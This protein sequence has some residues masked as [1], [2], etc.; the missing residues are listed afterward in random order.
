MKILHFYK[1]YFPY[2]MGGIEQVINQVAIGVKKLGIETEVL[3]LT[4]KKPNHT[5]M[6]DGHKVH[7]CHSNFSF[8]STPF[9]LEAFSEFSTLVKEAD[10]IH[11]HFPYPFTDILHFC[12]RVKK[13]TIV[14]YHL[15]IVKQKHLL[16]L[17]R[18]LMNHFLKNVGHIVAT[19]PNYIRTSKIL[20]KFSAKTTVIPIGL[21]KNTYPQLSQEKLAYWSKK[22]PKRFFLF[23]GVFRYYKGLHILLEAAKYNDYPIVIIGSGPMEKQLKEQAQNLDLNNIY[24]LGALDHEDK[25]A[26]LK[27][28]YSLVFPSHLRSE[29]FGISLLE[30]AMYGKPLISCEIGTGTTY[31]NIDKETGMVV[32]A[33]QPQKLHKAMKY[34]WDNQKEAKEM[35]KMAEIR[36]HKLFTAKQMAKSYA[37][38]YRSFNVK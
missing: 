25:V 2:N 30:G 38:L 17:Y 16:S 12:F 31:I 6:V 35:G 32:E 27:L 20:S 26:L 36:Y 5:T 3:A 28:C 10:I 21:D 8:A 15:D 23:I 7:F 4:D 19:S 1:S 22:F 11:Y 37:D 14:T 34:L 24:F 13:P 9:S 33:N 18:P 29:A